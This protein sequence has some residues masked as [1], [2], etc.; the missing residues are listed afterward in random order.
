MLQ[1]ERATMQTIAFLSE[2]RG[3]AK[4]NLVVHLATASHRAAKSVALLD[5]EPQR[6]IFSWAER[7]GEPPEAQAITTIAL[8]CWL[9]EAGTD[10]T[11][12]STGRNAN[13]AG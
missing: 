9:A 4:I 13:N 8:H 5:L 10:F 3:S 2:K 6:S 11:F 7:C 12:P 1:C